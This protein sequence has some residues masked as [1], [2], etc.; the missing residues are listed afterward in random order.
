MTRWT[1]LALCAAIAFGTTAGCTWVE[2]SPDSEN[3]RV[4][5]AAEVTNCERR[6]KTTSKTAAKV[7]PFG[8]GEVHL[9]LHRF[10]VVTERVTF[11]GEINMIS[12]GEEW[13]GNEC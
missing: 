10:K 6:G 11:E 12:P 13:I 4:A 7:G 8:R 9:D 3:I 1:K 5:T 2:A